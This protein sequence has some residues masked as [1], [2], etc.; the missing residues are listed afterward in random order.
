[1]DVLDRHYDT[2]RAVFGESLLR[3]IGIRRQWTRSMV[4]LIGVRLRKKR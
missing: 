2:L 1:M 4:G 3:R